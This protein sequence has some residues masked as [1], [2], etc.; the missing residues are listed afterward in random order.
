MLGAAAVTDQQHLPTFFQPLKLAF[1]EA[2]FDAGGMPAAK[3]VGL[4]VQP[5]GTVLRAQTRQ[6]MAEEAR[7]QAFEPV[8]SRPGGEVREEDRGCVAPR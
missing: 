7:S 1:L 4:T 3:A 5:G 2:I 8:A 6:A